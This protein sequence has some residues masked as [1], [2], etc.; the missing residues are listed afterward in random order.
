MVGTFGGALEARKIPADRGRL[1]C[2]VRGEV[3]AGE[4]GV[5]IIRKIH[6]EHQIVASEEQR[7]VIDR[8]HGVYANKC[9]V[10]RSLSPAIEIT[11]SYT[12]VSE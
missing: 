9:P 7:P 4:D 10:Y 6:V 8:V 1:T 12:I 5:M 3:Y 11:S 2:N